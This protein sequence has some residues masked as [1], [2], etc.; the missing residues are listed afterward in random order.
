MDKTLGS[1]VTPTAGETDAERLAA[2][3]RRL[4]EVEG[5]RDALIEALQEVSDEYGTIYSEPDFRDSNL[6]RHSPIARSIL[7]ETIIRARAV[8]AATP[9]E[10]LARREREQEVIEAMRPFARMAHPHPGTHLL[11]LTRDDIETGGHDREH[12]LIL[13][14]ALFARLW[15]AW[16]ALDSVT[17]V[18]GLGEG[19]GE[20]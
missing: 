17:A 16:D 13:T 20:R 4:R 5:Q 10:L 2:M 12:E 11:V 15:A 9:A 14:D 7:S 8:L 6:I 1:N 18:D 19:E 3:A